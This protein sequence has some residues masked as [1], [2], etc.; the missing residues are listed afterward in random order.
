M[1]NGMSNDRVVGPLK[2]RYLLLVEWVV[3]L[4][5]EGGGRRGSLQMFI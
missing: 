1:L 3:G 4:V 5:V 2:V